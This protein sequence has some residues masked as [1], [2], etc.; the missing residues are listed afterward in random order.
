[1]VIGW[2]IAL[3]A[4]QIVVSRHG[5]KQL[6]EAEEASKKIGDSIGQSYERQTLAPCIE[7]GGWMKSASSS[8]RPR[9][10]SSRLPTIGFDRLSALS[11][12]DLRGLGDR[13]G[14][15][16]SQLTRRTLTYLRDRL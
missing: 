13:Q 6:S 8:T 16:A 12:V 15:I 7:W 1:M 3:C 9:K 14:Q 2:L 4:E 11:D 10:R 5:A